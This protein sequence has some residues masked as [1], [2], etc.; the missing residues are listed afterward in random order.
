MADTTAA[1]KAE[2]T[3]EMPD[4]LG[5]PD[6]EDLYEDAG[7]LEFF[8]ANS[9]SQLN[10]MYL[11]RLPKYVWEKWEK[12]LERLSDEDEIQ[13]ATMR[14]WYDK[15]DASQ[16][17][18]P[19]TRMLL[20]DK[21]PEHQGIPLEYKMDIK[22]NDKE[23]ENHFLFSEEDLPGFKA[24]NKARAAALKKGIPAHILNKPRD[25]AVEKPAF[26]RRNRY[27]PFYRK[28]IPKK[29]KIAG[30][31]KFDCR[32]EPLNKAEEN[33]MIM[34]QLHEL[35][36]PKKGIKV[37]SG[38]EAA[39]FRTGPSGGNMWNNNFV[40]GAAPTVKQ[41]K[42]PTIKA[43]RLPKNELLDLLFQNF[44]EYQYH[45]MKSLRQRT[46]QPEA[47]LREVL[48]EIAVLIKA[49]PFANRYKLIDSYADRGTT[50]GNVAEE[51]NEEDEEEEEEEMEDVIP[52]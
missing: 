1:I 12:M 35:E 38:S 52:S 8:D 15:N 29:T 49:G 18:K 6:E 11:A 16:G 45:S 42:G 7:D 31:F 9:A 22:N 23:L 50:Q 24:K 3:E 13:I 44:N 30:K 27:Q 10:Q 41:K 36:K 14:L 33:K 48:D 17:T 19:V 21:I 25:G 4:R 20:N 2:A 37:I 47:W 39:T 46:Q 51:A 26:D 32:I 34:R 40:K 28:A 5:T 43:A